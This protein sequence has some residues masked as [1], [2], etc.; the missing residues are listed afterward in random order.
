MT[1]IHDHLRISDAF[2]AIERLTVQARI[3]EL[4]HAMRAVEEFGGTGEAVTNIVVEMGKRMN[5]LREWH[6]R[7]AAQK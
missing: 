4:Y 6:E 2:V 5:H 7:L 3:N 1:D